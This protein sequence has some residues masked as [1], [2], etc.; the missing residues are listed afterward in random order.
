M[1]NYRLQL[2]QL[3]NVQIKQAIFYNN[4]KVIVMTKMKK[5]KKVYSSS[6]QKRILQLLIQEQKTH[7]QSVTVLYIL[8]QVLII[9]DLTVTVVL[10]EQILFKLVTLVVNIFHFQQEV[11]NQGVHLELNFYQVKI[12]GVLDMIHLKMID[13]LIHQ[14]IGH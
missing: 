14:V 8:R 5:V 1:I 11:K 2:Q 10:K 3:S 9:S 4:R 6:H 12:L 7:L 13:V